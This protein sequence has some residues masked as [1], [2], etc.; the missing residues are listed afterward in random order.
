MDRARVASAIVVALAI[1]GAAFVL[2]FSSREASAGSA[3][4]FQVVNVRAE[5]PLDRT[6]AIVG[7]VPTGRRFVLRDIVSGQTGHSLDLLADGVVIAE[8]Q[9]SGEFNGVSW[10]HEHFEAGIVID[11]G[12]ELGL[13]SNF[14]C[15]SGP[16]LP[17][18]LCGLLE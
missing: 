16:T 8:I 12:Q 14:C 7:A 15:V 18:I 11:G 1:V 10:V 2:R 5:V 17:V 9:Q 4:R 3:D 6:I 13:R